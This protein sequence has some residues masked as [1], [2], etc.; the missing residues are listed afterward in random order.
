[1]PC[2]S[3][4]GGIQFHDAVIVEVFDVCAQSSGLVQL[5][6]AMANPKPLVWTAMPH[7]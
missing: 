5:C 2:F 7:I 4:H 1:L 6:L 3:F